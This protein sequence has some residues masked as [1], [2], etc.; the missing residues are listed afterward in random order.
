[1]EDHKEFEEVL[2]RI[3]YLQADFDNYRK[4]FEKEKLKIIELANENLIIDLLPLLDALEIASKENE[5]IKML[6][7]KFIGTLEKYGLQEIK[8]AGQKLNPEVHEV[9]IKEN[10]D[11]KEI[12][13]I[14][15]GYTL[16]GKVIRASKVKVNG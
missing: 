11:K 1:M 12:E 3:K 8:V 15:K 13:E 10:S 6:Q 9:L 2:S 14:Q 16:K 7:K 4:Q 5:G